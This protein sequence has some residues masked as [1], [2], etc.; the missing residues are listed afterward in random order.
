MVSR[1]RCAAVFRLQKT[2]RVN[3]YSQ[4]NPA[5]GKAVFIGKAA[6]T[7][8]AHPIGKAV[9]VHAVFCVDRRCCIS[10]DVLHGGGGGFHD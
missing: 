2:D 3:S 10:G 9:F 5:L 8:K 4:G 7:G 1:R 6:F